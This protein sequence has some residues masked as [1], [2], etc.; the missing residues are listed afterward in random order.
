MFENLSYIP[1]PRT[2][3]EDCMGVKPDEEVLIVGDTNQLDIVDA[4]ASVASSLGAEVSVIIMK[5]R[6][7]HGQEPTKTI[8]NAMKA[9]DVVMIPT[10]R[11]LSHTDAREEA[12][13]AGARIASMPTIT[14]EMLESA[15]AADYKK[16]E[17]ITVPLAKKLT[18]SSKAKVTTEKGTDIT[19]NIEGREGE[20]DTGILTE[21][22]AF[23][24][25]PAG[26][27]Y[28]A[29][30]EGEGDGKII[31]DVS[32]AGVGKLTESIEIQV[33]SGEIVDIKGGSEAKEL[34]ELI[35]QADENANKIAELGIGTNSEAKPMGSILVDEK[36]GDTVHIAFGDNSH[37]GGTLK[38]NSHLDGIIS[39]PTLELDGEV[40]MDKG[41]LKI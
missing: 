39:K 1:G 37:M 4:F 12:T 10:S 30:V 14:K 22:G 34:K 35:E 16:I 24:N 27:A 19:L 5:P 31:V 3:L 23:G 26:E 9:A 25:L 33:K 20:A 28:L 6:D 15:M 11:S 17:E 29:P 41:N 2:A 21:K 13:K 36:L 8:A 18:E 40:I 7:F 38:S 32:M